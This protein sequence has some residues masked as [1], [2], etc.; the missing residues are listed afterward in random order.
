MATADSMWETGGLVSWLPPQIQASGDLMTLAGTCRSKIG[1]VGSDALVKEFGQ[2]NHP[3][4]LN[5]YAKSFGDGQADPMV[6]EILA[7]RDPPVRLGLN[8]A[9]AGPRLKTAKSMLSI[10][11]GLKQARLWA[12]LLFRRVSDYPL[13]STQADCANVIGMSSQKP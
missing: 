8:G 5:Y 6:I 2:S 11:D 7:C 1:S 12:F 3:R 13:P 10:L 4:V 9:A